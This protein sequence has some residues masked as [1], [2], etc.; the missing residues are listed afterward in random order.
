MRFEVTYTLSTLG[1]PP[2]PFLIREALWWGEWT[3]IITAVRKSLDEIDGKGATKS[4]LA[5]IR[6]T[7]RGGAPPRNTRTPHS[8]D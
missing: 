8:S 5:V 6:D 1:N 2:P 3:P 7:H 4:L